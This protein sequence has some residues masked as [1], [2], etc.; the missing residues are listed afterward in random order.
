MTHPSRSSTLRWWALGAAVIGRTLSVVPLRP[1]E[2]D[3][4]SP[5]GEM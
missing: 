2:S 5:A 1:V 3:R 4:L